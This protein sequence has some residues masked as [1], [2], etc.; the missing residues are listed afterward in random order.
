MQYFNC[1]RE[2]FD[3]ELRLIIYFGIHNI[4]F[5]CQSGRNIIRYLLFLVND[6]II[7]YQL[8]NDSYFRV[9]NSFKWKLSMVFVKLDEVINDWM[10]KTVFYL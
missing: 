10:K 3:C 7:K 2:G 9:K 1:E 8:E 4:A 5:N 6:K